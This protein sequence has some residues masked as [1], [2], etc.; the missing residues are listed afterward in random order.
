VIG[1]ARQITRKTIVS[2]AEARR[3][4]DPPVLVADAGLARTALNWTPRQSSLD[5]I[6]STAWAWM[7]EHR[8][9]VVK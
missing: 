2:K 9:K 7:T 8:T 6:L 1:R 3:A 5:N 4:G